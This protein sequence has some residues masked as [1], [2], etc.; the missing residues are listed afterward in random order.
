MTAKRL[1]VIDDEPEFCNF[2]REVAEEAG[3]DVIVASGADEF[4]HAYRERD[5]G[6]VVVDVVMPDVDGIELV[7]WLGDQGC[8]AQVLVMTGYNP[9]YADAAVV[10]G[11]VQGLKVK[12]F[13]KPVRVATLRAALDAAEQGVGSQ[14]AT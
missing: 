1:L 9:Q 13:A 4:R 3:Y 10:L 2:V 7:N 8:T 14:K 11:N 5:P 12:R 6:V